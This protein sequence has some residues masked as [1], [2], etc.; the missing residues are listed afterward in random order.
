M[1]N[2]TFNSTEGMTDK[3]KELKG[4]TEL[5]FIEYTI[6]YYANMKIRMDE[7]PFC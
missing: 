6:L 5:K 4:K 7:D 1:V 2:I 3:L